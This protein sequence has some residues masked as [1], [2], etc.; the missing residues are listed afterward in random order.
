[1]YRIRKG[2]T[3]TQDD[4]ASEDLRAELDKRQT[5]DLAAADLDVLFQPLVD[6]TDGKLFAVEALVRCRWEEYWNP[7]VLIETSAEEGTVGR[8]GRLIREV[9]FDRCRDLP[10]F[11]NVHPHEL[12]SRWLVRPDDPINFHS[13]TVYV[14]VTESAAFEYYELCS[15][16]LCEICSRSGAKLVIDDLGAGFSNLKRVVD[17]RPDVVKVDRGIVRGL[18]TNSR[19]RVLFRHL[20]CMC[21]ELGARVVAEGIETVDELKAVRD[22]GADFGQGYLLARPAY[23]IS[24]LNWPDSLTTESA[25]PSPAAN[26]PPSVRRQS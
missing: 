2:L 4:A 26:L 24:A 22:G 3:W 8:L 10:L 19:Q 18:D 17:L 11:I 15:D 7:E 14:E 9:A 16:V 23:P 5:R 12:S 6:L 20:V 25:A 1:M 13:R 21:H